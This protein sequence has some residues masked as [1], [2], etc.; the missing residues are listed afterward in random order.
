MRCLLPR[1]AVDDHHGEEQGDRKRYH[2]FSDSSLLSVEEPSV[3]SVPT[4]QEKRSLLHHAGILDGMPTTALDGVCADAAAD[5]R[6]DYGVEMREA[7][8]ASAVTS[9]AW[10]ATERRRTAFESART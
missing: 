6:S 3:G 8:A 10:S 7:L 1:Q 2:C 5:L 4:A 9:A